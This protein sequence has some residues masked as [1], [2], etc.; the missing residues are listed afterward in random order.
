M[1]SASVAGNFPGPYAHSSALTLGDVPGFSLLCTRTL[2]CLTCTPLLQGLTVQ[3]LMSK[4]LESRV[5]VF[6]RILDT[7]RG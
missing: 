6:L 5:R 4:C 2:G 3:L 1:S 7:G